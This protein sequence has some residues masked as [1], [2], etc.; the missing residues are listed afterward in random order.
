MLNQSTAAGLVHEVLLR[1]GAK[2]GYAAGHTN[3]KS[4]TDTDGEAFIRAMAQPSN[5]D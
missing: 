1:G 3:G 5:E 2:V 4:I